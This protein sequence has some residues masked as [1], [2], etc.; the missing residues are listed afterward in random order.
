[1]WDLNHWATRE[2]PR[3][4]RLFFFLIKGRIPLIRINGE[5]AQNADSL[6]YPTPWLIETERILGRCILCEF[7]REIILILKLE[8]SS[9]R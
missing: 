8:N 9:K 4:V 2:V 3:L 7:P 6:T 5:A 1:M